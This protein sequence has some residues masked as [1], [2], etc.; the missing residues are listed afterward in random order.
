MKR[1]ASVSSETLVNSE[2]VGTWFPWNVGVHLI[3]LHNVTD[4]K[5]AI[6]IFVA[7]RISTFTKR[8]EPAASRMDV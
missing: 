6:L 7:V 5:S 2:H 1:E 8:S 4:R 3:L